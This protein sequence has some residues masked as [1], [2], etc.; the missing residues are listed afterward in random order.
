M[1]QFHQLL[2]ISEG[3]WF[4]G[5]IGNVSGGDDEYTYWE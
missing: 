2:S 4:I 3:L 1:I 5:A